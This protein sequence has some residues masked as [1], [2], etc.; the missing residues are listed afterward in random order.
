[1]SVRYAKVEAVQVAV[2]VQVV[3]AV[4]ADQVVAV[5]MVVEAVM[6]VQVVAVVTTTTKSSRHLIRPSARDAFKCKGCQTDGTLFHA[7]RAPVTSLAL[8]GVQ[9]PMKPMIK[10]P[11][12]LVLPS[13][14]GLTCGAFWGHLHKNCAG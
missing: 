2:V 4:P 14:Y 6:A 10:A 8:I 13:S 9:V 12:I 11:E 5:V 7:R 1:M 3:V